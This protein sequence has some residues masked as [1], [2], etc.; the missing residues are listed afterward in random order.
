MM[1]TRLDP[2]TIPALW[3]SIN[4]MLRPALVRDTTRTPGDLFYALAGNRWAAWL[5]HG[6]AGVG[7]VV[8]EL[9]DD[10]AGRKTL[11]VRYVAGRAGLS[12]LRHGVQLLERAAAN[13]GCVQACLGGRR[14]WRRAFPDYDVTLDNGSYVELRK[15]I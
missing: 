15:A 4:R 14:G 2:E 8:V 13:A 6:F 10:E 11:F 5:A 3:P 1:L 12:I 7:I 9:A